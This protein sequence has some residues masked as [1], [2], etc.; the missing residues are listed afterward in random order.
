MRSSRLGR[1]DRPGKRRVGPIFHIRFW[2]IV[3][4]SQDPEPGL[5]RE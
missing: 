2:L 4:R 3:D 1:F 5:P